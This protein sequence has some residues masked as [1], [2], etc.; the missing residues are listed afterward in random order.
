MYEKKIECPI[1][2]EPALLLD[3]LGEGG[4]KVHS[5]RTG[6]AYRISGSAIVTI[7]RKSPAEKARITTWIVDQRMSGEDSPLVTADIVDET[8][9]RKP[10]K[11]S[12]RKR[13]FFLLAISRNFQPS[14]KFKTSNASRHNNER[15]DTDMGALESWTECLDSTEVAGLMRLLDEEGLV[16]TSVDSI[17]ITA[18]GFER[19]E[20]LE[21]GAAP[22]R[23]AF[24]AMWFDP[25]MDDAFTH[26]FEPAIREAGYDARKINQKE[27]INKVDDE[28]IAEIRRSRFVIADFTSGTTIIDGKP[29]AISRGGVYYEAGFAQGLNVPVIWTCRKDC[30]ELIHFDTRQYN[31]IVWNDSD[32][33]RKKL[34]DRIRAVII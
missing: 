27:H 24:V 16:S 28:I 11:T 25:T 15:Y 8:S 10:L 29:V 14:D 1:W 32:D 2:G 33:L 34:F 13:R 5:P 26:G 12:E 20:A 19:M 22:T 31:H 9:A 30:I 23:Q 3:I 7:K 6:G 21:S 18:K 17:V 4:A